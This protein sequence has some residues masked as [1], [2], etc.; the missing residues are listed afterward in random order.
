MLLLILI[1][2]VNDTLR[3]V[4]GVIGAFIS[5]L[6]DRGVYDCVNM[7]LVTDHGVCVCVCVFVCV[8]A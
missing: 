1:I 7:I 4:D 8:C 6:K 3:E 5:G 2:Q